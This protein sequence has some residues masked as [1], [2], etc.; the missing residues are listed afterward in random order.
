MR[1]S[2]DRE[3]ACQLHKGR[4]DE[5]GGATSRMH[6]QPYGSRG[7]VASTPKRQNPA[8]SQ[9]SSTKFQISVVERTVCLAGR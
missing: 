6:E 4:R 8:E 1:S 3:G 7:K 9:D 5:E 2:P